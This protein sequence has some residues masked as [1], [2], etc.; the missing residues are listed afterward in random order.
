MYNQLENILDK[1]IMEECREFTEIRREIWHL[2]T[3]DRHLLKF[4]RLCHNNTGGSSSPLH[5][6]HGENGCTTCITTSTGTTTE[7]D[8]QIQHQETHT[9]TISDNWVRNLSKTPLTKAQE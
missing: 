8:H 4:K 2:S 9:H 6:I 3:L 5:G 7:D 1:E